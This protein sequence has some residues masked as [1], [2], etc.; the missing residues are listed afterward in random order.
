MKL[1]RRF[2][3]ASVLHFYV[4]AEQSCDNAALVQLKATAFSH[5][6]ESSAKEDAQPA[7]KYSPEEAWRIWLAAQPDYNEK[8]PP[9]PPM[10]IPHSPNKGGKAQHL[11]F[12]RN[13]GGSSGISGIRTLY[14]MT[15]PVA[16]PLIL[17]G[18]F[19]RGHV[20]W[21]GGAIYF[22]DSKEATY[23]KA[24]GLDSHQGFLIEVV[25][26]MG[27]IAYMP[28]YCTSQP[29]CWG[30]PLEQAIHCLDSSFQGQNFTSAGY[31]S[32]VFNPGDGNEYVI[33]DP[34]RVLSKKQVP[35]PETGT[36]K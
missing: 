2:L 19:R 9:M 30:E 22:A 28:P 6:N 20:G 35:L 32:V 21:C 13:N 5:S 31:D 33:W 27:R 17:N 23:T 12:R 34:S 7:G 11:H 15:S 24:V 1:A 4:T 29:K 18:T 8:E 26:D 3:L 14:H 25:V 36:T 16:G 10:A